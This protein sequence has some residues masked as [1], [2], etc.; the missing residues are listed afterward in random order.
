MIPTPL[1]RLRRV[2]ADLAQAAPA[3]M[4]VHIVGTGAS[5]VAEAPAADAARVLIVE[6]DPQRALRRR[7]ALA[8]DQRYT[9]HHAAVSGDTTPRLF[10]RTNF[11]SLDSLRPASPAL[12]DRFP[13]LRIRS[14]YHTMPLAPATLPGLAAASP[15]SS[16]LRVLCLETP[17]ESLG[18]LANLAETGLLER[19]E[20]VLLRDGQEPLYEGAAALADI[21]ARL[22]DEGYLCVPEPAPADPDRPWLLARTSPAA[23]SR[24]RRLAELQRARERARTEAAARRK[25]LNPEAPTPATL[26]L[27]HRHLHDWYAERDLPRVIE[28]KSLPRSGLHFLQACFAAVL[29]PRFEFCEWYNEP[30]CCRQFP[31]ALSGFALGST[32][33]ED[34]VLR[35][36][37]S[38]DFSLVDPAY[39]PPPGLHRLV[40]LRDPLMIL[41]SWWELDELER[42]GDLL[43]AEGI[44]PQKIYYRHESEVLRR[45]HALVEAQF[46]PLPSGHL[47]AWLEKRTAFLLAFAEKWARV[48][49]PQTDVLDYDDLPGFVSRF[50]EARSGGLSAAERQALTDLSAG[51]LADFRPRKDPYRARTRQV[52]KTLALS[53]TRFEQACTRLRAVDT[54]GVLERFWT[55]EDPV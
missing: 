55:R 4:L 9:V 10:L 36:I 14:R 29:G 23:R 42:H 47:D 11:P 17:G 40:L 41:T 24:A 32:A 8:D 21:R 3:E 20:A 15:E 48:P 44:Y 38:H 52:S 5:D 45:A 26:R 16:G 27:F 19:F 51:L 12:L 25:A 2:F 34:A 30:G 37:K 35:M 50:F 43:R 31:C 1:D 33:P 54:T 18:V 6:A 7:A 39:P 46:R 22:E 13:G 49:A 28:T 53:R